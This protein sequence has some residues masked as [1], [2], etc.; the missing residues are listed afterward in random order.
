MKRT[1][2]IPV[3]VLALLTPW[4]AAAQQ[5]VDIGA[6]GVP[7]FVRGDLGTIDPASRLDP[8]AKSQ[9]AELFRLSA[10]AF[11]QD[12]A[13]QSLGAR[14]GEEM[15]F[16]R[17]RVDAL[18]TAHA[19]FD[20]YFNGLRVVGAELIVHA[21]AATGDVY[22]VNGYFAPGDAPAPAAARALELRPALLAKLGLGG[23]EVGAPELV[24]FH[25]AENGRTHLTW[26]VNVRRLGGGAFFDNDLYLDAVTGKVVANIANVHTAKSRRSYDGSAAY[27]NTSGGISGLPGVLRCTDSQA[28][29]DTSV[30]QAHD[31]AGGVYD[32]YAARFGRDSLNG[33]GMTLISSAHVDDDW[34]NAAWYAG[35]MVYGDGDGSNF[36]PLTGAY[37]VI[38]HELTHGVTDYESDLLYQKES[39]ALNEGLSDIFGAAADSYRRGG[40]VD[41]ATWKLGED[42]YTPGTS[43]DAL[44]YM[45]N[46]TQ[47]GYSKDYYPERLYPGTCTPSSSNDSCGVHGNSGIANLAFK[48]LVT[49][50]IHP[51]NKTTANVPA[52]GMLKA[53]QIFYRAQTTYLTSSSTFA[54][55]R[56]ATSQAASELYGSS[57]AEK[58]AVE[59]AWCAVG[60][61][62][63]PTGGGGG[64][65]S[66][67]QNG[68]PVSGLS[69]STGGQV[70]Y[71][72]TVPAGATNLSVA[73]AGGS[74]DA[75]LYVRFGS[76][77]TTSTYD[78]R[79]YKSG[80]SETC[81]FATPSAGTWHVMIRAYSSYSGVTLT[82]SWT[83]P[84]GGGGGTCG[85]SG[86]VTN[87]SGT[88]G[89]T[90]SYTWTVD[91]C[92][93][94]LT[95]AMSGGTG[96]AD[97]Y[98]RFGSAPTTSTYDCRPYKNGNNET[99]TFSN[100]A[101]GT[102][103]IMIRGYSSYSGVNLTASHQ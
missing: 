47:D 36:S 48:L 103:H 37:D 94:S 78:C 80:N 68:V 22:A 1:L 19:R 14:G 64:G 28:C 79:P 76:A 25:D 70:A 2:W 55:A 88:S 98:V 67:L 5:V 13:F 9:D 16:S 4:T 86:S 43:G 99:C 7:T 49:G 39:G 66:T 92:A 97:L 21:D 71:T 45:A 75:D 56:T 54:A 100:P 11:L 57:S 63:C 53:E 69:G 81:T 40:A 30:Q 51:R 27:L 42:I 89:S 33:S 61:G 41:T 12:F 10:K 32:Y 62:T 17:A 58:T 24:Y 46:P 31:G 35:Q 52:I 84:S 44:R 83:E 96:D 102:W 29:N 65:G 23:G 20:Q 101:A 87:L 73:M 34:N 6:A 38:A 26:K 74:G 8:M 3:L 77:P 93:T 90:K 91:D 18:G 60:V 95:V 85:N 72:F 82:A 59:T 50:G 15:V